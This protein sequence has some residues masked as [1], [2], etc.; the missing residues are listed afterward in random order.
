MRKLIVLLILPIASF[1]LLSTCKKDEEKKVELPTISTLAVTE[2]TATTAKSGGN[3]TNDGG[4]EIT[5]KGIVWSTSQN[6]SF[7]Q[8]T[9]LTVEGA[10]TGLFQSLLTGLTQNTTYYVRAYATNS[11]GTAYGSQVQ[12]TT[13]TAGSAPEAAFSAN[14][15]SGTAPLSV[16]FTDQ[17]ANNPTSWLW[18]FGDGTTSN[19]RNPQKTYNA[20]G[21]YTVKLTATNSHGS[22]AHTKN[23][24]ITVNAAGSA[25]VA[26]FTGNPT[27]GTAPLTV[28]FTDQ[29]THNPTSW[30]WEFGDGTTST[31]RNPQKTY[32][33]AGTY[34]VKLTATNAH[35]SNTHT[36]NNF[37]TVNAAGSAPVAAFTGSPT[38]GTAPLTV[39][40]T[41]Q[42]TN[43]P[44]NWQ[45][46]FGDGNNSSQQNPQHTYQNAGT[47]TVQ[48][49]VA[50]NHGSNS[51]TKNNYITVTSGGGGGTGQPC[52]G[53][54][55]VTDIDGNVYNTVLIGDQCWMKENLNTTRDAAGN[56]ITRYCYDNNTTNCDLYG[57]LYTWATVM[58]GAGS[59]NNNP[60]GV[61]GI[62]PTGW[63]VPS[64]AE[65]TQ[66]VGYIVAQGFPNSN[67]TNGAGNALKSCRQLNSPLG[68]DCNTK[69]HPRWNSSTTHHG[70]DE[71]GFSALPGG[72]RYTDGSLIIPGY[73]GR[74][75]S[76]REYSSTHAWFWMISS[77]QGVVGSN[78]LN[79]TW[80]FSVRCLRD[81]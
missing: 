60:S 27:S 29:S 13:E 25:P 68:G 7:E 53:T 21:T 1:I 41:D 22:N 33:T 74:W 79:K 15:T 3:V 24:F 5:S 57:G 72:T 23:N 47:Y 54:P 11:T 20:T 55:T 9:G 61:Q 37:I 40:F 26:A 76:S 66:L 67:A 18:E 10:G 49:T 77:S 64:D 71:F 39:S 4:G 45:W 2:I 14:P 46:N 36:K 51:H 8:H 17:S 52:P 34:T 78:Y 62:C 48:L 35:G 50:N 80:G 6:P 32:N 70:F 44:T 75:W 16:N 38:S 28:S 56:N 81:N 12:F 43:S 69:E 19:E 73:H 30:L 31:Q 59:S 42:S 58:N 63:H 65:W